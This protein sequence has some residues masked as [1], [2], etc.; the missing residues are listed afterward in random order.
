MKRKKAF[1]TKLHKPIL[2]GQICNLL[3]SHFTWIMNQ[4]ILERHQKAI[5][6]KNFLI[7]RIIL[8]NKHVVFKKKKVK[9]LFKFNDFTI[10]VPKKINITLL[11]LI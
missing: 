1:E 2:E 3:Y 8:K 9:Y 11:V 6:T 10:L 4:K 7:K 5:E